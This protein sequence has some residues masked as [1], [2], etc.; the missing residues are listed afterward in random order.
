MSKKT[1]FSVREEHIL[2][3]KKYR[4]VSFCVLA[5]V[6]DSGIEKVQS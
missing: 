2:R 1:Y 5:I 4:Y 3:E 6:V